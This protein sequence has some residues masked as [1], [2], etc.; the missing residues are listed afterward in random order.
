MEFF[1]SLYSS[2]KIS[3]LIKEL[4]TLQDHLGN[5]NDLCIQRDYL[6][7]IADE[8]PITGQQDRST[9][10]AIGS[11]IGSLEEQIQAT[12]GSFSKI[13]TRFTSPKN[14]ELYHDL[15]VPIE[16]NASP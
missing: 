11:L 16:G 3:T 5:F 1:S 6:R 9:I 14:N 15:F 2:E 10:L 8:L 4:K 12:K 7:K 13:F